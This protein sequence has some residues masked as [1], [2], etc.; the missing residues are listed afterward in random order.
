MSQS[1]VQLVWG[2]G[3]PGRWVVIVL[4]S[5][6]ITPIGYTSLALTPAGS[7]I[8]VWWPAT[9]LGIT[10]V[11]FARNW[12]PLAVLLVIVMTVIAVLLAGNSL[13]IALVGGVVNG[14]EVWL[15]V[16]LLTRGRGPVIESVGDVVRFVLTALGGAAVFGILAGVSLWLILGSDPLATLRAALPSHL[17]A[18]TLLV[19]IVL[20]TWKPLSGRVL[21]AVIQTTAL[22]AV[23][24]FVFWPGQSLPLAFVPFPFLI[25]G[26]IR[27]GLA[28]AAT[29]IAGVGLLAFVLTLLGGGPFASLGE[30][31]TVT[32]VLQIF[33]LTYGISTLV[34][35]AIAA[36]REV[37]AQ[38]IEARE[39]QL[40]GAIESAEIGMLVVQRDAEDEVTVVE[41]NPAAAALLG[42]GRSAQHGA[43]RDELR[44]RVTAVWP[45]VGGTWRGEWEVADPRQ[46][47]DSRQLEVFASSM[48]AVGLHSQLVVQLVDVTARVSTERALASAVS[49]EHAA[50]ESLRELNARQDRLVAT[51]SHELRTPIASILGFAEELGEGDLAAE[52]RN[53]VAVIQR[54]GNR[55]L[56]LVNN[57][58]KVAELDNNGGVRKSDPVALTEVINGCVE[59]LLALARERGVRLAVEGDGA[60]DLITTHPMEIIQVLTNLGSNA[61]K[62]TPHGGTVTV[63]TERTDGRVVIRVVDDGIGIP[64]EELSTVLER[65]ARSSRSGAVVGTGLGLSIVVKLVQLMGGEF[66]LESDGSS[67]TVAVVEL[68]VDRRFGLT[69][70]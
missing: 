16:A 30:G 15:V 12:R 44:D 64:P 59:D 18:D 35:G 49:A 32:L 21:E 33:F 57:L 63:A 37:L 8:A 4:V 43:L 50:V 48:P 24:A 29:Q 31:P 66:R 11:L 28:V 42:V 46:G 61:I 56:H 62:F 27:L 9:A 54:N 36:E 17:S 40:I 53:Y 7:T 2:M 14:C 47:A 65:F 26:A 10:A 51:V 55:L 68:P 69:V 6:A 1:I 20:V 58:L 19:A 13:T 23:T 38:R 60:T 34:L 67:G 22:A 45:E 25:W 52:E 39:R 41:V 70:A 5:L 3:A